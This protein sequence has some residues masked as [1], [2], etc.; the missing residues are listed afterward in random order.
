MS[1]L[2]ENIHNGRYLLKNNLMASV[3]PIGLTVSSNSSV[4]SWN[5]IA[6]IYK[7]LKSGNWITEATKSYNN[8]QE[9]FYWVNSVTEE[10]ITKYKL[11]TKTKG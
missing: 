6:V 4:T 7:K 2:K 5:Y 9:A 10:L 11:N 3:Y 1:K 8:P